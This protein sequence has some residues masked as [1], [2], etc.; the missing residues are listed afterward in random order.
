MNALARLEQRLGYCFRDASLGWQALTH[1]SHSARHNER[2]EFLGDGV[3]NL[4][5][6]D[7]L[8]QT[9][10][11]WD[12]GQLS[13][14][15]S[16][17]V[18]RAALLLLAQQLDLRQFLRLGEGELKG[19]NPDSIRADAVEA[20]M[21]ALFLDG[22]WEAVK[23]RVIRWL[24]G[25]APQVLTDAEGNKDPKT[26]LQEWLQARQW[27]LPEYL[28]LERHG[29]DHAPQ[30]RVT[31]CLSRPAMSAVGNGKSRREAE[32]QAATVLLAQ[33]LETVV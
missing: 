20:L 28:R 9:Y 32:Q 13:R 21:G 31:C 3:L 10:P 22:G 15:R 18:N 14:A 26:R 12:E 7:W 4:I 1:R 27:P 8:Y 23:E 24:E 6:A 17:L 16:L 19:G 29:P 33:L 5:A 25:L 30:F 11:D 2:L